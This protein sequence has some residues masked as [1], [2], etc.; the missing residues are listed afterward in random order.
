ML[1]IAV[2]TTTRAQDVTL[3]VRSDGTGNF[4]SVQRALDSLAS[5]HNPSLGHVTLTLLGSFRERV[6]VYANFTRGVTFVGTGASPLDSLIIFNVSGAVVGTFSSWTMIVE[7]LNVTL[8]NIAVA[9]NSN[10]YNRHVA[11]QSVALHL[12]GGSVNALQRVRVY[13]CSLLGA[14]DTLYTGSQYSLSYY[15]N[16]YING[17]VDAL[18]GDSSSVFDACTLEHTGAHWGT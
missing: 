10:D 16:T 7:A 12:N 5:G 11:G 3:S 1:L 14:Q 9:N 17:S 13:N 4:T 18:F 15:S 2:A 8:L 6:H